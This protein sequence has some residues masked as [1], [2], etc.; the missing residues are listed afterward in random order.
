MYGFRVASTVR[1]IDKKGYG[2]RRGFQLLFWER[3]V[4][5]CRINFFSFAIKEVIV[6]VKVFSAPASLAYISQV[7]LFGTLGIGFR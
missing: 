6:R 7:W 2:K 4:V 3:F 5:V 1:L